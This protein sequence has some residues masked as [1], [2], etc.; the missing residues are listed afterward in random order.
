VKAKEVIRPDFN[1][2]IMIDFQGAA[3]SSDVG[4]LL[5]RD[6]D[7]RFRIIG[8]IKE[9]PVPRWEACTWPGMN[10]RYWFIPMIA[11]VMVL[12][13]MAGGSC[14]TRWRVLASLALPVMVTGI[15]R[16]CRHP[17]YIDFHFQEHARLFEKA[18]K[19]AEVIVPFQPPDWTMSLVK[20]GS[21]VGR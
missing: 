9:P 5:M 13:W 14:S 4:F 2:F 15:I 7:E 12:F 8:P 3:I 19:G 16:D 18:P 21:A 10:G 1:R 11:F 17:P 20:G 6:I